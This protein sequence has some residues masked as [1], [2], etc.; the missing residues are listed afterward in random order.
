M[1]AVNFRFQFIIEHRLECRH[2]RIHNDDACRNSRLAQVRT[3]IGNGNSQVIRMMFLQGFGNLI[4]SCAI[5]G[6]L[7]HTYHFC[8]RLQFTAIIIQIGNH[9]TEIHLQYRFVHLLLQNLRQLIKAELARTFNQD[10]F[11]LQAEFAFSNGFSQR[12][13]IRIK[14]FLDIKP[15]GTRRYF[16]SHTDN[17]F[18]SPAVHQLRHLPVKSRRILSRLQYI[19]K[20]Q[21]PFQA[22]A[23]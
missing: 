9:R 15:C 4:R 11:I 13:R 21:C 7:H 8:F 1:E 22:L 20:N 6:S 12:S 16:I 2:F 23:L 14:S 3:F 17:T 10:Y 18:Y 19:R 5:S